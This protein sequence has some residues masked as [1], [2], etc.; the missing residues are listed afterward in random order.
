MAVGNNSFDARNNYV[1]MYVC[2]TL[3]REVMK[4]F[5]KHFIAYC[6]VLIN[7]LFNFFLFPIERLDFVYSAKE[8]FFNFSNN[9]CFIMK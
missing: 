2:L 1:H 9:L 8:I 4:G 6:F 3:L 5:C 7:I